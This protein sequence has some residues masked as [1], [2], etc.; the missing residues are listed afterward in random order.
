MNLLLRAGHVALQIGVVDN[1]LH[2][3]LMAFVLLRYLEREIKSFR[4]LCDLSGVLFYLDH[5]VFQHFYFQ[6]SFFEFLE[7][8]LLQFRGLCAILLVGLH[9]FSP[10]LSADEVEDVVGIFV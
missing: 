2:L 7:F 9:N 4:D 1:V 3:K 6:P 5:L 10:L 8:V